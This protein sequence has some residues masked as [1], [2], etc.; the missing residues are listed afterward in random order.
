MSKFFRKLDWLRGRRRKEAELREE[1]ECHLSDQ[2]EECKAAG[3]TE[4]Q[5]RS[6]AQ[7]DLGN[8]TLIAEETRAAWGWPVVEQFFRDVQFACRTLFRTPSF[9]SAAVL[10]LALGIGPT[11]AIF[12]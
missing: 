8:V 3:L 1:L 11:S 12:S 4:Q 7:R 6:A 10:T 2:A 9:T 5:A